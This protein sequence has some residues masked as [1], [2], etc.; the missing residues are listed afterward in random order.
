MSD[1]LARKYVAAIER[2]QRAR[3]TGLYAL[4]R[5]ASE[6]VPHFFAGTRLRDGRYYPLFAATPGLAKCFRDHLLAHSWATF[7]GGLHIVP[8]PE[9]A[10]ARLEL[11]EPPELPPFV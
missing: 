3:S 7:L 1:E 10:R 11:E 5:D 9:G 6:R 4:V 8:A 2:Q